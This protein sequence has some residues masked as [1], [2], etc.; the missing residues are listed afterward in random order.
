[1]KKLI[2]PLFAFVLFNFL[3]AQAPADNDPAAKKILDELSKTTKTYTTITAE[4]TFTILGKD[5][6]QVDKQDGKIQVKGNKFRLEIPGNTIVSDGKTIWNHNKDQQE[7]SIKDVEPSEDDMMDPTKIFTMYE[8]G[9]K[10]LL[11][12]DE[13]TEGGVVMKVVKLY[14]AVKPEKKKYHIAKLYIVKNQIKM[15]KLMMRDGGEQTFEIKKFTPNLVLTDGS[16]VFDT[17]KFKKDQ[18]VDERGGK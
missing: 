6:K 12:K 16:F 7:V 10:Y 11:D 3:N 14:P 1:M 5:K 9:F 8:K 4:Y 15:V 13:K 17:S 18:I 2:L